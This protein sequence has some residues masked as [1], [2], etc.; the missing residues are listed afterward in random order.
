MPLAAPLVNLAGSRHDETVQIRR[1]TIERF[2]GIESLQF[3]PRAST[4]LLGPNNA[5]KST[6]L[7]ALDL[8]LHPGVGRAR[9]APEEVDYFRRDPSQG[10]EIEAVLGDLPGPFLANVH[11]HLEGWREAEAALVAEPDGEGVEPVVRVRV[12]GT[13]DFELLHEFAKPESEGAR[14]N[15]ARRTE[16]GWVFDG[17]TRDPAREL[18]FYQGGLLDRLFAGTDLDTALQALREALRGGAEAVNRQDSVDGVLRNLTAD[19]ENLGLLADGELAAF[20]VGAVSRRE[21]LQTLRL[22]LP[23]AGDVQIPLARQGRGAQRLVLVAVLLRLA[24]ARRL[25]PIGGFEEPEEALEPLRQAQLADMLLDIVRHGGQIFIVTH[26]PEI[27]RCFGIEDFL[28]LPERGAGKGAR[29]LRDALSPAVRQAYERHLEG[30]VVRGLFCR[31]PI[32]VEGPGDRAVLETFWR[33]LASAGHIRPAFRLGLDVVNAEGVPNMPMLAAVLHEAGKAVVPWVDQ[34]SPDALREVT[35]L[36]KEG[37]CAAIVVHD[38][39]PGRQNLEQALAW[40]SSLDALAC[41]MDAVAKDR[42]YSWDDELRDLMSRCEGIAREARERA[43]GARSVFEFL[44]ELDEAGARGL[45]AS[46][47]GAKGVTPFEMKG[48]RQAR[49]VA[50]TIVQAEGVPSNFAAALGELD[51]WVREGC[52][53]GHEIQLV[54]GA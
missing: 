40:G 48:A 5:A 44:G 49:I 20:E 47:L 3:H 26:S 39:A 53:P 7:E 54:T 29:H 35:R 45:V 23:G 15:P 24:S 32:L 33:H 51:A 43:K 30:P 16:V 38:P 41:A 9:P 22:A 11:E 50:E 46:A 13:S 1:V 37:H 18:F 6:V 42:G 36:R 17:R 14:F 34:D 8:L 27:A 28:L 2:R 21:L 4:V 52:A 12:R 31:V 25:V 19:F 10:F